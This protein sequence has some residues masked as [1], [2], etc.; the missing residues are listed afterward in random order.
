MG[1]VLFVFAVHLGKVGHVCQKDIDFDHFRQ[2]RSSSF[3]DGQD[4]LATGPGL[5][6]DSAGHNVPVSGGRNLA[7]DEDQVGGLNG[8]RLRG[9]VSQ[10]KR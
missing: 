2:T 5:I 1:K 9:A 7:R 6:G 8:L 3:Q 10:G 4:V